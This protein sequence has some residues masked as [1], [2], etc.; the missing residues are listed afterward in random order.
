MI[1]SHMAWL[2]VKWV[3]RNASWASADSAVRS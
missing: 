2:T 1:R 3:L